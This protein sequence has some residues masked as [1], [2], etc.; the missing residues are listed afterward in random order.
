VAPVDHLVAR[1]GDARTYRIGQRFEVTYAAS[2]PRVHRIGRLDW[3]F[4]A[5][6]ILFWPLLL[7]DAAG[8]ILLPLWLL[9]C[10]RRPGPRGHALANPALGSK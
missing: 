3:Q 7:A 6:R 5:R 8:Y 1:R 9:E 2:A 10:R 4:S